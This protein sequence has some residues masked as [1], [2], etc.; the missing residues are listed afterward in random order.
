MSQFV[1]Y[2]QPQNEEAFVNAFPQLNVAASTIEPADQNWSNGYKWVE[3]PLSPS[4][5]NIVDVLAN[6]FVAIDVKPSPRPP[7]SPTGR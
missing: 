3:Q 2:W 4:E 7:Y 5:F 1:I 6:A